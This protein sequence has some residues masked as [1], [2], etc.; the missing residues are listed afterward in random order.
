[1]PVNMMSNEQELPPWLLEQLKPIREQ[2]AKQFKEE[3]QPYGSQRI[4]PIEDIP[5]R[6]VSGR[7]VPGVEGNKDL[8]EAFKL[9]RKLG[10]HSPY[11]RLAKEGL[12]DSQHPFYEKYAR[13]MNPYQ[14]QVVERIAQEGNRNFT[15][16]ILPH[17]QNEYIR[18]G[19]GNS[20]R[21][22]EM[23][24]RAARDVQSE[25][26]GLQAKTMMQGYQ[27]AGQLFNSDQVRRIQ[28]AQ[29]MADLGTLENTMKLSDM[30][31]LENQGK[32]LQQQRQAGLDLDYANKV[33]QEEHK[34]RKISQALAHLQGVPHEV[35][36]RGANYTPA[37]PQMNMMGQLGQLATGLLGA[38]MAAGHKRG[39]H[40]R[41]YR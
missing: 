40:V 22:R 36:T 21:R 26:S 1:M 38:R 11:I 23:A 2:I 10:V 20:L 32:M 8:T 39:G 14:Q 16:N 17:L 9:G 33:E 12:E 5:H 24:N 6:F 19:Q 35:S 30:A 3:Y 25:I 34:A 29:G 37:A 4:A 28:A 27:Q 41:G 15:E 13:Y 31:A 18:S 7:H